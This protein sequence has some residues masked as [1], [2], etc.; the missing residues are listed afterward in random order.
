MR[1]CRYFPNEQGGGPCNIIGA[2]G[3]GG[4]EKGGR[5]LTS[6]NG[7]FSDDIILF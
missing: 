2:E 3:K 4:E 6:E 1:L 7:N 5:L